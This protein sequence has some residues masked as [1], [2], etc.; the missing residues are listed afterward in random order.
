MDLESY[1]QVESERHQQ[2]MAHPDAKNAFRAFVDG[3]ANDARR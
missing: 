1:L 2:V 3:R